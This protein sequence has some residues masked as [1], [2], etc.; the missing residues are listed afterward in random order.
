[1][2]PWEILFNIHSSQ[3]QASM[4]KNLGQDDPFWLISYAIDPFIGTIVTLPLRNPHVY[5]N[6]VDSRIFNKLVKFI[7]D[8]KLIGDQLVLA[9]EQFSGCCSKNE[10]ECWYRPI[11]EGN[12][13][14]RISLE[15]F[16]S[17]CP[18]VELRI[19]P[20]PVGGYK[21][22]KSTDD[23]IFPC[24]IQPLYQGIKTFWF[25]N[26]K[27]QNIEIRGYTNDVIRYNNTVIETTL[28]SSF[29]KPLDIVL[30]GTIVNNTLIIEDML[31]RDQFTQESGAPV[32]KQRLVWLNSLQDLGCEIT[33]YSEELDKD[34]FYKEFNLILEQGYKGIVVRS[35]NSHYPFRIQSDIS[36]SPNKTTIISATGVKNDNGSV[37]I[38]GIF[39]RGMKQYEVITRLGLTDSI[40][41][42]ILESSI[43]GRQF[44]VLS[45][46]FHD[47]TLLFPIFQRW[48][49]INE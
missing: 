5:G 32:L 10:W 26:T 34:S 4:L 13:S 6:G 47:N 9:L 22:I 20:P 30:F 16:N 8:G 7:L 39:T 38:E 46:G 35:S 29:K 40:C 37:S 21:P 24:V 41:S 42:G 11:L 19:P 48:R 31:T 1:M 2:N 36:V 27:I 44:E 3:D 45:C 49:E 28:L 12:L 14:V 15:V 43:I 18:D 23:I 33:Q 17:C 25:I